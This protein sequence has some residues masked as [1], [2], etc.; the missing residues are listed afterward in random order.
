M[1][2]FIH[3]LEAYC[4]PLYHPMSQGIALEGMRLVLENLPKVAEHPADVEARAHMM[5]AAAM[6]AVAF[7]K[8]LGAVHALSHP[9]GAVYNSH[10]GTT[11]AV[12]MPAVLRFNREA[13]SDRLAAAAAYFGIS[14]GYDGLYAHLAELTGSL[15]VPQ[16]L[17]AFGVETS[18]ID[19]LA[20]MAVEDPCAGGNP[21]PLTLDAAK[22]LYAES[23]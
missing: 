15:G 17:S 8:G 4:S 9:V 1:D 10:H 11:N 6:G 3:C 2:A 18:R 20:A 7:Q 22:A 23:L 13:V 14:G 16:G 12:V 21:L 19:E 5:S